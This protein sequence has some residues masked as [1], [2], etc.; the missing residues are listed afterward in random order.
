MT[1]SFFF[2]ESTSETHDL[3]KR[4]ARGCSPTLSSCQSRSVSIV[5]TSA[6]TFWVLCST[7]RH[8]SL[9]PSLFA[10]FGTCILPAQ[11]ISMTPRLLR[12]I[13]R[14]GKNVFDD[15]VAIGLCKTAK[16]LFLYSTA[17]GS[18]HA[19]HVVAICFVKHPS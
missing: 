19:L 1:T 17:P 8:C 14:A 9:T 6:R 2:P 4:Q 13:Y 12:N 16:S 18:H 7:M 15:F 5:Q 3:G 10:P 11:S